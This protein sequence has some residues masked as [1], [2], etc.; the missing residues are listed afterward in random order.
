MYVDIVYT[1]SHGDLGALSIQILIA[2]LNNWETLDWLSRVMP[3]ESPTTE[4]VCDIKTPILNL[5]RRYI[6]NVCFY[7]YCYTTYS[8]F[9]LNW[10]ELRSSTVE[11]PETC[12]RHS[13]FLLISSP[14]LIFDSV[15]YCLEWNNYNRQLRRS[16]MEQ[17]TIV[18]RV[19]PLLF[20]LRE[21]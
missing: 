21:L 8:C 18:R 2:Y 7:F 19:S 1:L 13:C 4:Y 15:A 11:R 16:S 9:Y 3:L 14:S 17:F 6:Y 12:C 5:S 10:L 20:F